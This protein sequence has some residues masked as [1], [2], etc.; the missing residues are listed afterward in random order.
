MNQSLLD[1]VVAAVL[2]EGYILYPYRPSVKNQQRWTFGGIYPRAFSEAQRGA[3]AWS[4]QTQCIIRGDD[5]TSL[6]IKG[7]FLHLTDRSVER[8]HEGAAGS[9]SFEPV[10]SLEAGG[11]TYQ[12]WQEAVQRD[13]TLDPLTLGNLRAG[14]RYYPASF[15]A[16][17]KD[18]ELTGEDGRILGRLVREQ[19]EVNASIEYFAERV[20]STCFRVTIG[21]VNQTPIAPEAVSNRDEALMRSLVSTHTILSVEQGA[22]ISLTDPPEDVREHVERCQNIGCW[23]V[24]VGDSG[25]TDTMLSSPIILYDYPQVAPESPGDLFD[26]MEIDEIL[27]LRIMTLTDGE[28]QQAAAVD[29]RVRSMLS[30]TDAL[31]REQL[32]GLH[33]KLRGLQHVAPE[34]RHA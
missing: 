5:Q 12:K 14:V 10:D 23:P 4:T 8:V 27:T 3:D 2:Y 6:K 16:S 1:K 18:Q 17:R 30:R 22:F 9:V 20:N 7:R 25:E 28:K 11:K 34:V 32:M 15:P 26:S 13:I 33:G 29:D 24:L 31:A 19:R 21:I